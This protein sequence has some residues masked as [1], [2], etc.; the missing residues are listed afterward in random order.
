MISE[1]EIYVRMKHFLVRR[2][3]DLLGGDP[4]DGTDDIPV[5]EVKPPRNVGKGSLSSKKP[6]LVAHRCSKIM[7][8]ELKSSF[9]LSD[10]HKLNELVEEKIW[11]RRIHGALEEK[12]V[13]ERSQVN[14]GKGEF[15]SEETYI[16]ALGLGEDSQIPTDF[17][18]FFVG[19]DS[20]KLRYGKDSG[21]GSIASQ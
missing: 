21:Y 4:P 1:S 15:E 2:G 12:K 8:L 3:W 13:L 10:I 14:M 20:I 18:L 6:D 7:L 16:K 19:S 11:R 17:V 9:S 5:I